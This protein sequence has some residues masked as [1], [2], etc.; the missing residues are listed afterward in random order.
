[1]TVSKEVSR[2]HR[3]FS[4]AVLALFVA[5]F[6]LSLLAAGCAPRASGSEDPTPVDPVPSASYV[7]LV[8]FFA[9]DQAM[10]VL[11]ELRKI[12]VP[13]D[14]SQRVSTPTLVVQELL[15][16]PNDPLLSK[17]LPPEAKLLSVEVANGV[18]YV[19]FSKELQTKHWGGSAGEIMTIWSL[20]ASLTQ[21]EPPESASPIS[22]VQILIE[23]KTVETLAGHYDISKPLVR[24]VRT[25]TPF[26][27]SDERAKELQKRV[28]AGED[29]WRRDPLQVAKI[30]GPARGLL[31]DLEYVLKSES[32]GRAEVEVVHE[33]KTYKILLVQPVKQGEG[34]VWVIGEITG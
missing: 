4:L 17:T 27:T 33:G 16:G 11:P 13:S 8:L 7:D 9:D 32:A 34:G 29:E 1:M 15:K 24:E 20:V 5:F 3:R 14:P 18:A 19:N 30:E 2:M 12:E 6:A 22:K 31:P 26:F 21:A 25:D 10:E 23:G 28:D